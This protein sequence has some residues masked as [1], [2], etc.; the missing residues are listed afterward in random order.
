LHRGCDDGRKRFIAAEGGDVRRRP[1]VWV[2]CTA[3]LG[4]STVAC[5]SRDDFAQQYA[6]GWFVVAL[7]QPYSGTRRSDMFDRTLYR[8]RIAAQ[9]RSESG[10]MNHNAEAGRS[11]SS[12]PDQLIC[13]LQRW[14]PAPGSVR[15][16]QKSHEVA[17]LLGITLL[18]ALSL[19]DRR[20][21]GSRWLAVPMAVGALLGWFR[22]PLRPGVADVLTTR[23]CKRRARTLLREKTKR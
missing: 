7:N 5:L 14:S 11:P 18:S 23:A 21:G 1:L 2:V 4:A 12:N 17:V 15:L 16:S 10:K 20:E 8:I 19:P 3:A 6:Y 22:V 9:H 13:W